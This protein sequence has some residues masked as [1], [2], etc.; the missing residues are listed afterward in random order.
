M[1][2]ADK[3]TSNGGFVMSIGPRQLRIHAEL[4]VFP[5]T[6]GDIPR[7]EQ[8]VREQVSKDAVWREDDHVRV[9]V[10]KGR[11]WP[12]LK[13]HGRIF[14]TGEA[15][16]FEDESYHPVKL[17]RLREIVPFLPVD[18]LGGVMLKWEQFANPLDQYPVKGDRQLW[19]VR[20]G[21][22]FLI[23]ETY[24]MVELQE[25]KAPHLPF[26]Q[27]KVGYLY[28]LDPEVKKKFVTTT[29]VG[30]Y[31]LWGT[32]PGEFA[33]LTL[34]EGNKEMPF[35]A[36]WAYHIDK[37]STDPDLSHS[38]VAVPVREIA[39]VPKQVLS[40]T[41]KLQEQYIFDWHTLLSRR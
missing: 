22:L 36:T 26:D 30:V 19:T 23:Q 25:V 4:V 8:V 29:R 2:I 3:Q 39:E 9:V 37:P 40:A 1:P 6:P 31:N 16:V 35:I 5:R 10:R 13:D 24:G 15:V 38:F 20:G 17:A 32:N 11:T 12:N 14:F 33:I 27:I 21:K 18:T 28:E 34:W 7:L 41:Y